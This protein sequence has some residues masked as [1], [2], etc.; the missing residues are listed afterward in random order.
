MADERSDIEPE[1]ELAEFLEPCR[2]IQFGTAAVTGDH[3]CDAIEQE[4]I[5]ARV[6][7]HAAFDVGVNVDEA[8]GESALAGVDDACRG[9]RG[10]AADGGD[11]AILDGEVGALPGIAAAIH[12][13]GVADEHVVVRGIERR[14][15]KK[16]CE[17]AHWVYFRI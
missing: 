14:E 8:G 4:I 7:F 12:D 17:K 13:T 9:G 2:E 3:G 11:A 16:K 15:A 10:K 5:A 1:A 6:P